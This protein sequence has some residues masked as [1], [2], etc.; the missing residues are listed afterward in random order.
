[1]YAQTSLSN[2][3]VENKRSNSVYC[4]VYFSAIILQ[5]EVSSFPKMK[6]SW[7]TK[8]FLRGKGAKEL[9]HSPKLWRLFKAVLLKTTSLIKNKE[10][11]EQRVALSRGYSRKPELREKPLAF[12]TIMGSV[13][14]IW[15]IT[16]PS[17]KRKKNYRRQHFALFLRNHLSLVGWA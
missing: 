15:V 4:T 1:M 17:T 5:M 2:V 14:L 10:K 3:S 13:E 9:P 16:T 8:I 7:I 12:V 6:F 11:S